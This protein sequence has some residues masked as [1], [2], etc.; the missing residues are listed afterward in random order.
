MGSTINQDINLGEVVEEMFMVLSNKEKNVIVQ[1]FSLDSKPRRTLESIGQSFSVTRER[2]RQ[3]EKI[4]LGKLKRTVATTKLNV[5]NEI[6]NR[7][8]QENGGVLLE[9]TLVAKIL[10]ELKSGESVDS[11]IVKLALNINTD[12]AKAEKTNLFRAYWSLKSMDASMVGD[13]TSAAMKFLKK[14]T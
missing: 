13:I 11:H 5:V 9:N 14:K 2:I 7:L 12:L 1:R 8:L 10:N 3:I 4:A 6:A